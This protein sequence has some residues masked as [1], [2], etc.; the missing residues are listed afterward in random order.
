MIVGERVLV[1]IEPMRDGN[2]F[3]GKIDRFDFAGKKAYSPEH[4]ANGVHDGGK[5]KIAGRHFVQHGREEKEVLAI[6]DR[7]F[8]VWVVRQSL[9]EFHRRIQTGETPAED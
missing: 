5:V 9:F 8:D 2:L 4:L 1:M 3:S 7:D 6:D